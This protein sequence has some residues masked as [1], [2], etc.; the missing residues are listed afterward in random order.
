MAAGHRNQAVLA[1]HGFSSSRC[2]LRV[3][4]ASMLTC[5]IW[6]RPVTFLCGTMAVGSIRAVPVRIRSNAFSASTHL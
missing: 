6:Q 3:T 2:L 1:A 5:A 4:A